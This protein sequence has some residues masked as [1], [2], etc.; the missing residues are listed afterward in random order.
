MLPVVPPARL[1]AVVALPALNAPIAVQLGAAPTPLLCR[2]VPLIP[3]GIKAVV[4]VLL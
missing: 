4:P 3:I 1:V 2:I